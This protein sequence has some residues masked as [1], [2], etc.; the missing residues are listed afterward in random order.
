MHRR[1]L[2]FIVP[3]IHPDKP[4]RVTITIWNIIFSAL[5]GRRPVDWRLVFRDLAQK[6]VAKAKK[7]KPTPICLFLY[8]LYHA[9]NI[10]PEKEDT[11]YRAAQELIRYR[12]IPNPKPGSHPVSEEEDEET[13]NSEHQIKSPEGEQ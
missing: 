9:R 13:R 11:D 4:T 10:L 3:I 8:H 2:E 7:A 1:L 12:I 6:L 5:D